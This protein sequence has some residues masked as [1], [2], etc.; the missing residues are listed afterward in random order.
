MSNQLPIVPIIGRPN[1]GKSTL[2]NRLAGRMI[3]IVDA[4]AGVTR[5]RLSIICQAA[6][7]Y[8]ELYDTGGYGIEDLDELGAQVERQIQFALAKADLIVFLVDAQAGAETL[9][10]EMAAILRKSDKP[11]M[12]VANKVDD[13]KHRSRADAEFTSFGFGAP[14]YVSALHGEGMEY[15]LCEIAKRV[16]NPSDVVPTEPVMEMAIVGPRNAGKSTFINA[17]AGE[18]RV[19]VSEIPGTT[20]DSIDVRFEMDG[21]TFIAIDTAGVRRKTNLVNSLEFY[22]ISRSERSI[23]RADVILLMLDAA[24][25]VGQILKKLAGTIVSEHK[26]CVIVINKWDLAVGKAELEAYQEYIDKQLTGL[27]HAP[28][29]ATCARD[30]VNVRETVQIAYKLFQQA[31]QRLSTARLN[32]AIEEVRRRRPP[33]GSKARSI[34]RFYYATQIGTL[35]PTIVMFVND[36]DAFTPEYQRYIVNSLR[37][38]LPFEE[39]PIRLLIRERGRGKKSDRERSYAKEEA[40]DTTEKVQMIDL[41]NDPDY[42]EPIDDADETDE[43]DD[44]EK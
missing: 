25:E 18:E 17:L 2:F 8:I 44:V 35:P 31:S 15:L 4:V 36:K 6:D 40:V 22:G 21:R 19:I 37:E 1:V 41:A 39:V 20:R 7:Q 34:P 42:I 13:A 38:L 16:P 23:R 26:P 33:T 3:S 32:E 9:D 5:D 10:R 14:V 11:V 29:C 28:I 30:G 43:I 12:L 24:A 27:R